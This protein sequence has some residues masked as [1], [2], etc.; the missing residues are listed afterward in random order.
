MT[1]T[2]TYRVH[3]LAN[4]SFDAWVALQHLVQS[5]TSFRHL[6]EKG[7]YVELAVAGYITTDERFIRVATEDGIAAWNEARDRELAGAA[8]WKQ[9]QA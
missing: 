7:C 2:T 5:G 6:T 8:P 1:T 4:L 9:V 3:H